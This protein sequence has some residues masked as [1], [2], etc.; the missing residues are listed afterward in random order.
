MPIVPVNNVGQFGVISEIPSVELPINA[1]SVASN[2][3]F[4][5]G[6]AEKMPGHSAVFGT[7]TVDPYYAFAVPTATTLYWLYLSLLKAYVWDG[8]SHTDITRSTG[9]DYNTTAAE[10]YTHCIFGGTP[11]INN[12]VDNPQM[13]APV[14]TGTPLQDLSNWPASTTCRALRAFKQFLVALDLNE[15]GTRKPHKVRWSS[16]AA[17]GSL[18]ST[19][20]PAATND[21]GSWELRDTNDFVLDCLQLR[22]VN[23]I[24]KENTIHLMQYV[25]GLPVFRFARLTE[26]VGGLARRCAVEFQPGKHVVLGDHDLVV[27]DG[28]TLESIANRRMRRRIYNTLSSSNYRNSYTV[29]NPAAHEVWFCFV[30]DGETFPAIAYVWN[31]QD[32]TGGYR[33]LPN[34]SHIQ[35]GVIDPGAV[36]EQWASDSA[37][38]DSDTSIWDQRL[39]EPA[40][41]RPVICDPTNTLLHLGDD[42]TDFN[43]AAFTA[44]LERTNIP[45]PMRADLPPDLTLRK[46]VRRIWLRIL[47]TIGGVVNVSVGASNEPTSAPTYSAAVP[48]TIGTSRYVDCRVVGSLLHL[49]LQSTTSIEWQIS[50]YEIDFHPRGRAF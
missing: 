10:L 6:N 19:W 30:E 38:W 18:P 20:V 35:L 22:D 11:V 13:W 47:G 41:L 33:D 39:Y 26:S 23:I 8:S 31:Y 9:G 48:F 25:G 3:R 17:V 15:S 46:H 40:K 34:S 42:T 43:G 16:A 36:G 7:P 2:M 32:N 14:S 4:R 5:D 37:S 21:A 50:G 28:Y 49:K 44:T 1:W 29:H 24:Y 12:G 27:H 45:I